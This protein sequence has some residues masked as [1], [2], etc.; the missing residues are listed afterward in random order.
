MI[1]LIVLPVFQPF[2]PNTG[3]VSP[4]GLP[5]RFGYLEDLERAFELDGASIAAF[6]VEPVQ[7]AA[8]YCHMLRVSMVEH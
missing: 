3:A 2:L 5:V 8:G 7:G 6:I 1:K 4:T